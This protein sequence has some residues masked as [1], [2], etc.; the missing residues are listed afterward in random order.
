MG[1]AATSAGAQHAGVMGAQIGAS[2]STA[3]AAM[4]AQTALAR[5]KAQYA[6]QAGQNIGDNYNSTTSALAQLAAQQGQGLAG[7]NSA[8]TGNLAQLLAGGGSG[9]ATSNQQLA[10]M[11]SGINLGAGNQWAGLPGVPSVQQTTGILGNIGNAASGA[12][13]GASGYA[14]I[15]A[16]SD[17][18]LKTNIRRVG[19]TRGGNTV[20]SWN[21]TDEGA[22]LAGNQPGFGVIAQEV[23]QDA[24]SV[25]PHGYLMVDYSRVL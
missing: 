9:Q 14:A 23:N 4:A 20:Y 12:G 17:V 19:S 6:F 10:Q 8:Y 5:D 25:G 2:A 13:Q 16:L 24:V 21:W 15:K 7:I 18:R 11:L 1:N 22:R 3:S